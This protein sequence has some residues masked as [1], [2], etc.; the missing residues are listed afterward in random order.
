[1]RRQAWI[2]FWSLLA[3]LTLVVLGPPALDAQQKAKTADSAK[4]NL[5]TAS[6]QE[7]EKLP[8]IGEA[9]AK[10]IIAGRPYA[11]VADLAK[12]G[13]PAATIEKITPQVTVG[14]PTATAPKAGTE[15]AAPATTAK[16]TEPAKA[17]GA[18]VDLNTATEKELEELRGVGPATA[19][20]IIAGRPYASV[21]DL[22]KAGLSAKQ[23]EELTPQVTVGASAAAKPAEPAKPATPAQPAPAPSPS[24]SPSAAAKPAEPAKPAA[25]AQQPPVK[26]MVWVNTDSGIFHREG[27]RWY[28][29]TKSGKF[30]T[31]AD[32]VKEGYREAKK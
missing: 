2:R 25:Q 27:D 12:A 32:A 11:S 30:M 16:K 24:P 20:K 13:V 22:S 1:M 26:G 17:D 4:I 28:G 29:K 14:S 9:T 5:N 8:G 31:E 15:K 23:I 19:K 7:L 21:K 10:K 6:Q 18:K 3:G